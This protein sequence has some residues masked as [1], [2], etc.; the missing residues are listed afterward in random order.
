MCLAKLFFNFPNIYSI[1]A[2]NNGEP[3]NITNNF[4]KNH[5]PNKFSEKLRFILYDMYGS[6]H[7]EDN[8]HSEIFQSICHIFSNRASIAGKKHASAK[9]HIRI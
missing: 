3:T 7:H 4:G 9:Q 1:T 5:F 2:I 6:N 8:K